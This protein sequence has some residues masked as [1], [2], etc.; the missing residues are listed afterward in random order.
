MGRGSFDIVRFDLGL[1]LQGPMIIGK[2]KRAYNSLIIVSPTRSGDTVDSSSSS[3][4]S[5][6]IF[7]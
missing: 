3:S 2:L 1:L 7:C 5:A 4:A 6:E